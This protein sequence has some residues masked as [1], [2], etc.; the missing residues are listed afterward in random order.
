MPLLPAIADR[1]RDRGTFHQS[2]SDIIWGAEAI[3]AVINRDPRQTYHLLK[4]GRI[5]SARK[6]D[7][8]WVASRAALL[9]EFGGVA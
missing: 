7:N 6:L 8:Q 4:R 2:E 5:K 9:R 3:G 1:E